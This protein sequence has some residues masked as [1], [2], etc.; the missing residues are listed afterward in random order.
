MTGVEEINGNCYWTA[1]YC[2]LFVFDHHFITHLQCFSMKAVKKTNKSPSLPR[3][4]QGKIADQKPRNASV[5]I[6]LNCFETLKITQNCS[7]SVQFSNG[8]LKITW[9]MWFLINHD[10]HDDSRAEIFML[11]IFLLLSRCKLHLK[12]LIHNNKY[13]RISM[14]IHVWYSIF[15]HQVIKYHWPFHISLT[16]AH[17]RL[18]WCLLDALIAY[19]SW[20]K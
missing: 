5:N 3:Y 16:V 8:L 20:T 15:V 2:D 18:I 6:Q 12:S 19:Y 11:T 7:C 10:D 4:F 9:I 17:C 13:K 14:C 1:T